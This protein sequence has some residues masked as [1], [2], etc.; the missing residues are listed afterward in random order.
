MKTSILILSAV[1]LFGFNA[2][3]QS[4]KVVPEAVKSSFS[5]KFPYATNVKW[6]K[7][8]DNEWEAEF[9]MKGMEYSANFENSGTWTETEYEISLKDIPEAVKTSLDNES[10]GAKI[11]ESEVCETK[12]GK[13]FEFVFGRGENEMQLQIDDAGKI[14]KKE[15]SDEEQEEE[16]ED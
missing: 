10:A 3:D 12:E 7:E 16:D 1:V 8:N 14:I 6:D 11:K 4:G 13:V 5:Q 2:C 15:Q 9:K